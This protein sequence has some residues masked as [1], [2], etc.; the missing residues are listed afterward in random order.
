MSTLSVEEIQK[1]LVEYSGHVEYWMPAMGDTHEMLACR[2]LLAEAVLTA[3][4]AQLLAQLDAGVLDHIAE[5]SP[6]AKGWDV[7]MLKDT[8]KLIRTNES[9][10]VQ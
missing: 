4:Q 2:E 9:G 10:V 8:A 5:L 6:V 3:D 7:E 1:L